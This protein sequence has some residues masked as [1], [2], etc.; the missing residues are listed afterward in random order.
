[1][2]P[3]KKSEHSIL[4]TS[5][6]SVNFIAW[7]TFSIQSN[8]YTFV[9][10]CST[11]RVVISQRLLYYVTGAFTERMMQLQIVQYDTIRI[12]HRCNINQLYIITNVSVITYEV[13]WFGRAMEFVTTV[14]LI[15]NCIKRMK[16]NNQHLP[17]KSYTDLW[18]YV[19]SSH[20]TWELPKH[21]SRQYLLQLC[22]LLYIFFYVCN[23]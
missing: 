13:Y 18:L 21:M 16:I 1:L 23:Q 7:Y 6:S 20:F 5:N 15:W 22:S 2:F 14:E 8:N 17:S 10:V 9:G 4:V 12:Y 19:Q 3:F 11:W